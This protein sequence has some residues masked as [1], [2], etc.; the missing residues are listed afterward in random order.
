[1]GLKILIKGAG[2]LAT[3]IAVR[4]YRSGFTVWMTDIAMPTTV[5]RTVAFSSCI[6]EGRYE[7]EGIVSVHAHSADEGFKIT[8][9]GGIPVFTDP[10]ADI[11][12]E[13][14]P[15]VIVDAVIAKR[16]LGTAITDAPFVIA[17][18]PGFTAGIDCHAVIETNR[19]HDLGRVMTS[20]S[21]APNTGVPGNIG[22]YTSERIIRAEKDGIFR[23][24]VSIGDSVEYGDTVAESGGVCINALLSGTVRGMLSD[25]ISVHKGMKCGDIDPRCSRENCFTVSDKARAVGGGVLEAVCGYEHGTYPA[26]RR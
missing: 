12:H 13:F 3:G 2:D 6:T 26:C 17:A 8:E 7:V 18:G 4:L 16:N 1:M 21:A 15:D 11:A 20:G 19:G 25:G 24:A 5:R 10:K 14:R 22:G 23:S 9:S